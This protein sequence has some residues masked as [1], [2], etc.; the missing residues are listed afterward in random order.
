MFAFDTFE[1]LWLTRGGAAGSTQEQTDYT[2]SCEFDPGDKYCEDYPQSRSDDSVPGFHI[3]YVFLER[4]QPSH[5]VIVDT[6]RVRRRPMF[7]EHVKAPSG[8]IVALD[9]THFWTKLSPAQRVDFGGLLGPSRLSGFMS[10]HLALDIELMLTP[11]DE[12]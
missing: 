5:T 8:S 1:D 9:H 2:L 12:A 4:P 11:I 3:D 7:R 6:P 10:D